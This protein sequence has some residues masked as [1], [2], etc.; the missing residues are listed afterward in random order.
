MKNPLMHGLALIVSYYYKNTKGTMNTLLFGDSTFVRNGLRGVLVIMG[1]PETPSTLK[2][3][4]L[5]RES[6][7]QNSTCETTLSMHFP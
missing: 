3:V 6:R 1:L 4:F 7:V 2:L 5:K